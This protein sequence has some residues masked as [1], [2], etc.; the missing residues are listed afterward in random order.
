MVNEFLAKYPQYQ[1]AENW[2]LRKRYNVLRKS[3]DWQAFRRENLMK[4]FQ[5][6]LT[7]FDLD[8]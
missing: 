5:S 6:S 2:H 3:S 8:D 1:I 7:I 4:K